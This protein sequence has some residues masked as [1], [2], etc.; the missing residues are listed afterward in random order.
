[1]E[2]LQFDIPRLASFFTI[3]ETS[4]NSLLTSPTVEIVQNL[5]GKASIKAREYEQLEA[6]NT[7]L[8]IQLENVVRTDEAKIRVLKTSLEKSQ[9]EVEQS[10]HK[11]QAEGGALLRPSNSIC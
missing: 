6:E 9:K 7:R 1:M 4:L 3:P 10:R 11:L 2:P 5:L 8:E